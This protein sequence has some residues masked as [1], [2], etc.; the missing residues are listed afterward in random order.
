MRLHCCCLLMVLLSLAGCSRFK[1]S[2]TPAASIRRVASVVQLRPEKA[3]E[4]K[5]LH[6]DPFP[7]VINVMKA[8][9][10]QNCSIFLKELDSRLYL[11]AYFEFDDSKQDA[12]R[13]KQSA[14][15]ELQRWGELTSACQM[16]LPG[17]EGLWEPMES[18]FYME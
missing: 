10:M 12:E 17:Q 2:P 11:F 13:A 16:P 1:P 15:E 7:D 9:G 4:Y 3:E 18:V 6:A 5:A 8:N 14:Q